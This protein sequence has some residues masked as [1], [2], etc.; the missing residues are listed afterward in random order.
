MRR[1]ELLGLGLTLPALAWAQEKSKLKITGIRLVNVKPRKPYPDFKPAPGAWSTQYV[2]VANPM[3]IYPEFKARRELFF[4]DPGKVGGFTV[5]ITTDKGITGYG[6]GGPGGGPIVTDHLTKLLIGRDPFDIERNWDIC[7]RSTMHYGRMGVT[8]NAI[9]GVDLALWDIVG[10]ALNVPVYKLLGGE[11]KDRIPAYCTGNDIEQH[12]EFGYSKL[13]LAIPH[14]P[15]DGREGM[16]KNAALVDRARKAVGP[17]GEVMLDCWMAWTE[18]YT[19]EM[20]AMLE[21]YRVYWMEEVLQPHDYAGFGRLNTALKSTRIATGEHEYGRYGFRH[22][23][24]NNSASIWQP[25]LNWC[26][27]LTEMR[28]IGALAAAYDI[29]VIPHGGGLNGSSHW[30]IANTNAPWAELFLPSP[31][32]P[33]EVYQIFEENYNITRGPEGIYMRPLEK[34]GFG[35]DYIVS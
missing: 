17:D 3:S 9:S 32:G 31:G 24:E 5:E 21:P 13:K 6:S 35:W 34:P 26:G 11:T 22:L 16:R 28:R 7:W 23:L 20:A 10:K 27:G 15:A 4:A 14:G 19:L 12:V 2:E 29:P 30:I 18:R 25:D 1:R 8:M 33:K